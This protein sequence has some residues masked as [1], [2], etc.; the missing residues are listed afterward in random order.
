MCGAWC[1]CIASAAL[2]TAPYGPAMSAFGSS[3][4]LP[5]RLAC[6]C[7]LRDKD[8]RVLLLRRLK[9]PNKGLCSP[10]GGPTQQRPSQKGVHAEIAEEKGGA[11]EGRVSIY[12][13]CREL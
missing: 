9:D 5:Y 4:N 2:S 6:L 11:E 3:A 8:G 1:V 13:N 12:R 10:I 7:D